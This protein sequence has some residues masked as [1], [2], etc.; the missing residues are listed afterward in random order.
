M[1][2]KAALGFLEKVNAILQ[3][4]PTRPTTL[5]SPS[6]PSPAGSCTRKLPGSQVLT[7]STKQ[8]WSAHVAFAC[9]KAPPP[10]TA[11]LI[12]VGRIILCRM[13]SLPDADGQSAK[14]EPLRVSRC[15][16]CGLSEGNGGR[17]DAGVPTSILPLS[18]AIGRSPCNLSMIR[19]TVA[20]SSK[21]PCRSSSI[22]SAGVV[23][24]PMARKSSSRCKVMKKESS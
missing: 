12:A 24:L 11:K 22:S 18:H 4:S 6:A 7:A 19:W 8:A 16:G 21:T 9:A 10:M 23:S 17:A 20:I 5:Y 15:F 2:T 14:A 1:S 3:D 13:F